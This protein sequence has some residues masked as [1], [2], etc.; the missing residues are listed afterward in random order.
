MISHPHSKLSKIIN[1]ADLRIEE[2]LANLM[3]HMTAVGANDIGPTK[4][5]LQ[6]ITRL[7][8]WFLANKDG[9]KRRAGGA[10]GRDDAKRDTNFYNATE[11][12]PLQPSSLQVLS[13]AAAGYEDVNGGGASGR[14]SASAAPHA[15][16]AQM[17]S[18]PTEQL[19]GRA[20]TW[21]DPTF[22]NSVATAAPG[23]QQ[24]QQQQ[25]LGG[26]TFDPAGGNDVGFEFGAMPPLDFSFG[27][28]GEDLSGLFAGDGMMNMGW[29]GD[30]AQG[31]GGG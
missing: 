13:D 5:I 1:R 17:A 3:T 11:P 7:R 2:N 26:T 22:Y 10:G 8:A 28:L 24:Q 18:N 19:V 4:K 23:Q 15:S 6:I 30:F 31:W 9:V 25:D 27:G 29:N 20:H 16:T 12:Q 21:Y 14:D